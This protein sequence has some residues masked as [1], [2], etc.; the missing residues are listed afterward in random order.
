MSISLQ[1]ED[2]GGVLEVHVSGKLTKE[3][4]ASFVPEVD[5]MIAAHGKVSILFGMHDFH[6][7][8]AAALWE[9][10][11]FAVNHFSDIERLAVI[12]EKR[13]QKGMTT[14]CLPFTKA[15][16]RYFDH[17]HEAEARLWLHTEAAT[18]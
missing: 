13:W 18:M 16:I 15:E 5:R 17:D 12:G 11:K 3:D 1:E 7:W 10:T 9:D 8:K 6:G 4:Y 14:F 2:G